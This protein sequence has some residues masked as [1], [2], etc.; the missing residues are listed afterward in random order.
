M[1]IDIFQIGLNTFVPIGIRDKS[2]FRA[3][4]ST[5]TKFRQHGRIVFPEASQVSLLEATIDEG[6][7]S[8]RVLAHLVP[9][10]DMNY[11]PTLTPGVIITTK[12]D[13]PLSV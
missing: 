8:T 1:H 9:S 5:S 3:V 11:H 6:S 7:A 13:K 2:L 10:V 4:F 12:R